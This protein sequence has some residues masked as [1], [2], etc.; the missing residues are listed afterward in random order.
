MKIDLST[1]SHHIVASGSVI[2][3]NEDPLTIRFGL[4]GED[5]EFMFTFLEDK[6]S[7]DEP[8]LRA[9]PHGEHKLELCLVNF[10]HELGTGNAAPIE[11]GVLND[12]TLS[13]NYRVY[14]LQASDS[15]LLHYTFYTSATKTED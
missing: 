15:R 8:S 10:D 7:P 9:I 12:K 1:P 14:S 5:L 13:V 11:V 3:Y 6:N 2:T 4:E